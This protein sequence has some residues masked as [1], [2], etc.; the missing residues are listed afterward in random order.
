MK[1]GP[2]SSTLSAHLLEVAA[3]FLG[4]PDRQRRD[5]HSTRAVKLLDDKLR[6]IF[7][8]RKT[9][10][11]PEVGDVHKVLSDT[12]ILNEFYSR[13]VLRAVPEMVD[14]TRR[15]ASLTLSGLPD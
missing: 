13:E 9:F 15:L 10:A 2:P 1:K 6:I 4:Y 3:G 7:E 5:R 8:W 14:R 12:R 11:P